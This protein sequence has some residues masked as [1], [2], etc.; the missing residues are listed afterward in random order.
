LA[1]NKNAEGDCQIYLKPAG[2]N[3]V[4]RSGTTDLR[5]LEKVFVS[6]EY[7]IPFHTTPHLVVDA[8]AN[9][10]MATL[11]FAS[12]FP[13]ARIFAIEPEQSNFQIL[14]R[15]C[16]SLANVTLLQAA[17]WPDNRELE[18]LDCNVNK[19]EFRVTDQ[20]VGPSQATRVQG[21]TVRDILRQAGAER[22]D[23][24][25][26]DIEGSER[27]L[28]SA[29]TDQWLHRV[30]IIAIELHDR[31]RPGCAQALYTALTGRKFVQEIKG[32]NIF[33]RFID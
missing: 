11:Y 31:F 8:G 33:I 4:I 19:W 6:D 7:A 22:I 23:L 17:L 16:A 25:K 26:L 29:N 5:C 14:R 24:L 1:L 28:F 20:R 30:H 3:I 21:I 13:Q 2:R 10:G 27:D 15:N 18:I 12:Q 32:E 9:T